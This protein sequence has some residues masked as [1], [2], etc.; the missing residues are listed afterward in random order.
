MYIGCSNTLFHMPQ[1]LTLDDL[2]LLCHCFVLATTKILI[3]VSVGS[4][5]TLSLY[6]FSFLL[7]STYKI[8]FYYRCVN[9]STYFRDKNIILLSFRC[10]SK[11]MYCFRKV[12]NN[13]LLKLFLKKPSLDLFLLQFLPLAKIIV[14]RLIPQM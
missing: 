9:R 11:V 14:V 12:I 6:P 2:L 8:F 10:S 5:L 1:I 7:S 3:T 4:F 13:Q